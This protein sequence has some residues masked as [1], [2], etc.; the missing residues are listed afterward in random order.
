M[1]ETSP[2]RGGEQDGVQSLRPALTAADLVT[3][4]R[5]PL[6]AAFLVVSDPDGRLAILAAAG[7]TDLLDGPLARRIGG[8]RFGVLLDPLVD[9][10]FMA[11]AFAVVALARRLEPW[12][13]VGLL[14]RDLV[15][16]AAF[17]GTVLSGRPR[18]IA[19]R[20]AGKAV[21]MG[22]MATLLA[23]LVDSPLLR[24]LAWATG[25]VG[26]YAIWDYYRVAPR[27][28]RHLGG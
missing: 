27:A 9:K 6:A 2:A 22:Q 15:A 28:G 4:S 10:L 25:A 7:A 24:P 5:L 18:A 12:E 13:I 11:T 14:L 3:L 16:T 23:F 8:S 26:V 1:S 20:P 21:T 17:G 19:A